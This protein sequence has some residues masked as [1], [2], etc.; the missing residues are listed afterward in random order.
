MTR[1]ATVSCSGLK[2]ARLVTA[3]AHSAISDVTS[4]WYGLH[5]NSRP[6]ADAPR[7]DAA[8]FELTGETGSIQQRVSIEV[9]PRSENRAPSCY[10]DTVAE[11]TDGT[12]P[13]EV[14]A[15]PSCYDP[16]GDDFTMDGGPP[17]THV[18]APKYVPAGSSEANWRYR[19]AT[20]NGSETTTVWATDSLGARSTD[21][22]LNVTIGPG[23]GTP[24][25]CQPGSWTGTPTAIRTR[26]GMTRR[27]GLV[28]A[29]AEA[30]LF[31]SALTALPQR[32]VMALFA[33]A[34]PQYGYW[35]VERWIDAMYVPPDDSTERDPFSVTSIGVDTSTSTDKFE[36]VP[37]TTNYGGSCGWSA[38][39]IA[40]GI[41]GAVAVQCEDEEGDPFTVD[42]V[43]PPQH[44][45]V[46]SPVVTPG[47]FGWSDIS[48]PYVADPGYEGYDCVQ[49]SVS[50]GHG[51]SMQLKVD[52]WVRPPVSLPPLPPPPLP[53]P[54]PPPLP[55]LPEPPELPQSPPHSQMPIQPTEIQQAAVEALGT[56]SIAPAAQSGTANVVVRKSVSR[57]A[58]LR[59]GEAP[60][61]LVVCSARC[62]IRSE[63]RLLT[64]AKAARVTRH[65]TVDATAGGRPRVVAL[66]L[67]PTERRA[68]RRAH[69]AKARFNVTVKPDRGPG[70]VV[71]RTIKI[72]R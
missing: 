49:L 21:A 7:W 37:V 43:T 13:V 64:G 59:Y 60:A 11:R 68:L 6:D 28:C 52:I 25:S 44:G 66:T 40:A 12:S 69:R 1:S 10:G 19:T 65:R 35:G 57:R 42:V 51:R 72:T 58:L 50:D 47:R 29:D 41:A 33:Q 67:T 70:T 38:A 48:V 56:T 34:G 63:S 24:P 36:L 17:G 27:F 22:Q 46:T 9:V 2:S 71:R 15:H 62:E 55:E 32:G 31:N 30:D 26:A 5:F 16:D 45:T 18:G 20:S 8:V 3:P 4:D 23:V 14:F 61:M 54:P 53:L 39:E